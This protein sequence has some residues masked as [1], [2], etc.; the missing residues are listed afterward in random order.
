VISK[1]AAVPDIDGIAFAAFDVLGH[2]LAAD[3]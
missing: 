2:H 1:V 3:P